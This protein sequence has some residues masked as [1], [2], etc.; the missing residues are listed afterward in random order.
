MSCILVKE[1]MSK[2]IRDGTGHCFG[3]NVPIKIHN[4]PHDEL[5]K[6]VPV[7]TGKGRLSHES[8]AI[9]EV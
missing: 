6:L 4:D 7:G 1:K 3:L 8:W 5:L 9:L 2:H